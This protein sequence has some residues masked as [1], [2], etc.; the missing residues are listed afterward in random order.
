MFLKVHSRRRTADRV[1][2][3]HIKSP[4]FEEREGWGSLV[5]VGVKLGKP[6]YPVRNQ[7]KPS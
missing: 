1:S 2:A 3:P 4:P 7:R 6:F 5:G